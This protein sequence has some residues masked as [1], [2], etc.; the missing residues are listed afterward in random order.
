MIGQGLTLACTVAVAFLT[1]AL[2][3]LSAAVHEDLSNIFQVVGC[4]APKGSSPLACHISQSSINVLASLVLPKSACH[5][6]GSDQSMERSDF[7]IRSVPKSAFG[8]M[9]S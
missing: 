4:V 6:L 7:S 3:T 8:L 5:S 9:Q 2:I 1:C